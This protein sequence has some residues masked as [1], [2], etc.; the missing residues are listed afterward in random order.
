MRKTNRL[1]ILNS[2]T[3]KTDSSFKGTQ[4]TRGYYLLIFSLLALNIFN[5]VLVVENKYGIPIIIKYL[6][7][8]SVLAVLFFNK[9]TNPSRPSRNELVYPAIVFFIFWSIIKLL[10]SIISFHRLFDLQLMLADP[11]FFL[12]YLIPIIILFTRFDL[13]FFRLYYHYAVILLLPG[14]L[15]QVFTIV[16]DLSRALWIEQITRVFLFDLGSSFMLLSIHILKRKNFAILVFVYIL[17]AIFIL[18]YFGRRG[19]LIDYILTIALM[20]ILRLKS[21]LYTFKDRAIIYFSTLVLIIFLLLF[22]NIFTSSYV[23]QRGFSKEAFN[24]SRGLVF[25]DFFLDFGSTSDWIFGRGIGGT[26]LRTLNVDQGTSNIIE[27]GFLTILLKGGLLYLIPFVILLL[28]ASYLGFY[29]SN[30]DLVKAMA[31]LLLIYL[32]MMYTFNLPVFGTNYII[33]WI[34]VTVCLNS[35]SRNYDNE[36]IFHMIKWRS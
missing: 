25:E 28:R 29:R 22:T 4:R 36:E 11:Y 8:F 10:A 17:L 23:Y 15:V 31:C 14:L 12:P 18:S 1:N 24:E 13:A 20:I 26:V 7:S 34:S 6:L 27:N 21:T 35:K 16:F 2:P 30:N 9:F 3:I 19:I 32:I 5:Y 33:I